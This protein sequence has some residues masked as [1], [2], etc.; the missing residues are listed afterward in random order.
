MGS[1]KCVFCDLDGTL[2][3]S[4]SEITVQN[5][6]AIEQLKKRGKQFIIA[7]GRHDLIAKKYHYELELSTPMIACNGALIKDIKND[8]VLF[9]KP[10]ESRLAN[11]F[12]NYCKCNKLEH[13]V[14]TYDAIYYSKDSKR[15]NFIIDYNKSVKKELRAPLFR[16]EDFKG[17]K[18]II[19][20]LIIDDDKSMIEKLNNDVN[21]DNSLTI[22]SSGETLIDIMNKG[23]SKGD[24]VSALSNYL[25]IDL[26][27][28]VVLGDN[29]ND[30][31]MFNV[32]GLSIAVDNAEK[33]LKQAAD[34]ITLSNDESGVSHALYEFVLPKKDL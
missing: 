1:Y 2:L 34:Y 6:K 5:R 14:Y 19:K 11:E 8:K 20:F 22:V 12:L 17:N 13:L 33:L 16:I 10:I 9:M 18:E 26:K 32:A 31:S 28:T 3:N 7:T 25:N 21:T 24:A 4:H 27:E 23:I 30:L 29:H 15:I